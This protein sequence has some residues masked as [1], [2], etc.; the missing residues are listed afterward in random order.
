[1]KK[2]IAA[3]IIPVLVLG[4]ISFTS[5]RDRNAAKKLKETEKEQLPKLEKEIKE[6]VYPLPTSAA[7]IKQLTE[8]EVGYMIGLTNPAANVKKY[9]MSYTRSI[10]LGVYGA[11]LSYVSLYN[12]I[13]E[14]QVYLDV[15]RSLSNDLNM[16]KVYDR[17]LYDS[18]KKNVDN[19][20]RLVKI[21]TNTFTDTYN[22]LS[23]NDQQT[24]ALLVV[25]GAWVEG[26]YLTTN[27]SEEA[28]NVATIAKVLIDQKKSFDTYLDL[29][30]PYMDDQMIKDFV[31][32]LDPIKTVY[33]RLGTS[34][35]D[36]NIRDI[37]AAMSIIRNKIVQ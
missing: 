19:R 17:S 13:Q 28:Y 7:V 20:D 1:M 22:Y 5:C 34:L 18:I 26:M 31:K 29:A 9:Y 21:L 30:K 25:G 36:A 37:K 24:L 14:A 10:N 32:E 16:S 12:N 8:L 6:K 3:I 15:I 2:A 27:V 11:D 35:T 4:F 23:D 33:A